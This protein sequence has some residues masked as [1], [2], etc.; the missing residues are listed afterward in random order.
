MVT[1]EDLGLDLKDIPAEVERIKAETGLNYIECIIEV[2]EIYGIEPETMKSILPKAIKE[3]L[4]QD[5]VELNMV[6]GSKNTL[7]K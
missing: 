2:C 1:N 6:K 4:K 3:K 5:A 7:F